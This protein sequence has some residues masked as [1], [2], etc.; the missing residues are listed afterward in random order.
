[1]WRAHYKDIFEAEDTPYVGDV[2]DIVNAKLNNDHNFDRFHRNEI[3]DALHDINT[4]KSYSRH[5]HWKHISKHKN[6]TAIT[7]LIIAFNGWASDVMH[8]SVDKVWPLFDTN[9]SPIPKSGKKDISKKRSWRP[10]SIGT[11]ENWI[12]EKVFLR[13]LEPYLGTSDN[14][15][16]YKRGHSTSHAIELVRVLERSSDCHV[17][18]LDASSAFDKISWYRIRDEMLKRKIPPFLIK[19]CMKQLTSTR[20]SVCGTKFMYPRSGIKQGGVLSGNYFSICYDTL[21]EN[22]KHVGAGVLL[23][24]SFYIRILLYILIY[25][26]DIVLVSSSPYGLRKLIDVTIAFADMYSDLTFNPG[27]S[28][29]LRLGTSKLPPVSVHD[30]SVAESYEYLGVMI[31]RGAKPQRTAASK[32]YSKT[33]LMMKQNKEIGYCSLSVKNLVINSYGS[34][35][36]LENFLFVDSVLRQAHRSLTKAVHKDWRQFADLP[37]PNI[38]SRQL[39]TSYNVDSLEVLHRRRRNNFLIKAES[40]PNKL[41]SGVIGNLPRI[42]A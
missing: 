27:K 31:G 33:N 12:L 24:V 3:I 21:I 29:I 39:Y 23:N 15:F 28:C 35:Y 16:G 6:H 13:R 5:F 32:L 37:G 4:D 18:M 2:L 22:L 14:Q 10:I 38:R 42:T 25:A 11:S 26:D 20:I 1:M 9:L 17:C 7:C 34:V 30:I 41:I 40:S 36:S 19:L 8:N